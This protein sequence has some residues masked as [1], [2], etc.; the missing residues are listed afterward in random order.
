MVEN[1][2]FDRTNNMRAFKSNM[3]LEDVPENICLWIQTY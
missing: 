3:D 2:R 1:R